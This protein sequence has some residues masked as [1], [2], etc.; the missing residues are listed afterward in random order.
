[1][2]YLPQVVDDELSRRLDVAGAV[3]IESPKA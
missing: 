3:V 1:M 2:G